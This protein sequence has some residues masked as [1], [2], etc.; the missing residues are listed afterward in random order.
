M[1]HEYRT[2]AKRKPASPELEKLKEA[3]LEAD[4]RL[5]D[6]RRLL[7]EANRKLRD[8]E[9]ARKRGALCEQ[10]IYKRINAYA[11]TCFKEH[12]RGVPTGLVRLSMR[13]LRGKFDHLTDADKHA[14]R[15]EIDAWMRQ[16]LTEL[17]AN[18]SRVPAEF[19]R[20]EAA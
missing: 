17:E 14:W 8:M 16:W 11:Y 5:A 15:M 3:K 20:E 6:E 13:V 9:Y 4:R 7:V 10:K 1:L 19:L 2:N 18:L 12:Y